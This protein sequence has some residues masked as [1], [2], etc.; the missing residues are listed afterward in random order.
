[1]RLCSGTR[2]CTRHFASQTIQKDIKYLIQ[3]N[4]T[5]QLHKAV[6]G[7]VADPKHRLRDDCVCAIFIAKQVSVA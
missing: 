1:M 5:R 7:A 4:T 6:L 2:C 3:I